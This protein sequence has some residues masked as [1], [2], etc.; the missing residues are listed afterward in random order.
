MA[1]LRGNQNMSSGD[2]MARF[3]FAILRQKNLKDVDWTQVARD[4][5]LA[6][7]ITNGHAARMRYSRYKR[8]IDGPSGVR[9]P[10]N[11]NPDA[12][13]AEKTP[14]KEKGK[15]VE[16]P[17][18][19]NCSDD[20]EV[21]ATRIKLAS[22]PD[23]LRD[24]MASPATPSFPTVQQPLVKTETCPS[25]HFSYA[26]YS[27]SPTPV[28]DGGSEPQTIDDASP[29]VG[30]YQV[31]RSETPPS[32]SCRLDT[33]PP[34]SFGISDAQMGS[35]LLMDPYAGMWQ[36]QQPI[37]QYE[38]QSFFDGPGIEASLVKRESRWEDPYN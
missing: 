14:T 4:P 9:R 16:E 3:L 5:A 12:K 38:P 24:D 10:R 2:V 7:E 18:K 15:D 37:L 22:T 31:L 6:Q 11:K 13:K 20:E 29:S 27:A 36:S 23:T 19:R 1:S 28:Y 26:M 21:D 30:Q 17:I 35:S 34:A 32:A 33:Y 25:D 8:Q